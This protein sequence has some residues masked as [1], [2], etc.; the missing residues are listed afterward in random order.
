MDKLTPQQRSERM[1]RIRGKDTK[2]ELAVRRLVHSLGYRY[3][4][5]VRSLP[6]RPDMVF[7]ARRKIILV[8]GCFWHLHENCRQ[9]RYPQSKLDFW[10]PKLKANRLR[11]TE[12][13]NQLRD[14]GWETLVV[15]ECQI[16]DR[17]RLAQTICDFLG[18]E[19][20]ID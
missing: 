17:D 6:G 3:R 20:G 15:W 12:V 7:S 14:L 1:S 2:P 19:H 18:G 13:Q 9:Y 16:R 5:H 11:D 8:H 4:L 10:G